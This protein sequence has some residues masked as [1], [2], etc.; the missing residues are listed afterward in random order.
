M[1]C[2]HTVRKRITSS[3]VYT[4]FIRNPVHRDLDAW[5]YGLCELFMSLLF[6]LNTF[7][8][9]FPPQL[10]HWRQL[11]VSNKTVTK[12]ASVRR[13]SGRGW[14][15]LS[16]ALGVNCYCFVS[17]I[18]MRQIL[19]GVWKLLRLRTHTSLSIVFTYY[20]YNYSL[21]FTFKH[22]IYLLFNFYFFFLSIVFP[23]LVFLFLS[24]SIV[25]TFLNSLNY[26]NNLI[27]ELN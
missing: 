5:V 1:T 25:F 7:L 27:Y 19:E 23:F 3:K 20:Y 22:W 14:K 18:N 11:R 24:L 8:I 21:N 9:F 10:S 2:V 6:I 16:R 4:P 13:R 17:M 12:C 15:L 26:W